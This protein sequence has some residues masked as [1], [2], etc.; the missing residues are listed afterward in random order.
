MACSRWLKLLSLSITVIS[1]VDISIQVGDA[2][3][4]F[5]IMAAMLENLSTVKVISQTAVSA[6]YRTAQVI[7]SLPHMAYN[8]KA[9]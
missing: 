5:D 9:R 3:P 2:S 8:N 4:I 1:F 7:A 6:V